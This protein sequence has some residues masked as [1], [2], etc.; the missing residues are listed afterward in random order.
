MRK[1]LF[2]LCLVFFLAIPFLSSAS[3]REI[4][5]PNLVVTDGSDSFTDEELGKLAPMVRRRR[6]G[7]IWEDMGGF[8][9]PRNGYYSSVFYWEGKG[10]G[11]LRAQDF[12]KQHRAYAEAGSFGQ[13]L[14]ETYGID[15]IKRFHRLSFD[16]ER[17]WEAAFGLS[18]DELDNGKTRER[19]A[20]HG[21]VQARPRVRQE[22]GTK[23]GLQ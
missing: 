17:P 18:L 7:K 15:R 12:G 10:G 22:H 6:P 11:D 21:L 5:T 9:C 3:T 23:A 2:L 4:Q 1:R 13:Y 8:R 14:L 20:T 16:K 19:L